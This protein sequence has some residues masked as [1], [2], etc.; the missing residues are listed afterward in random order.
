MKNVKWK[1]MEGAK[2]IARGVMEA[3]SDREAIGR[4][5][6]GSGDFVPVPDKN[7]TI[8]AGELVTSSY[9]DE[10]ERTARA[11]G[12]TDDE[13]PTN[14]DGYQYASPD[15]AKDGFGQSGKLKDSF[16]N[17]YEMDSDGN[18][19]RSVNASQVDSM[20]AQEA[21]DLVLEETGKSTGWSG[22]PT[23]KEVAHCI[24]QL[25]CPATV[26]GHHRWQR[27]IG[28]IEPRHPLG[29][30]TCIQC[31][32]QRSKKN[33]PAHKGGG[34]T[35][36]KITKHLEIVGHDKYAIDTIDTVGRDFVRHIYTIRYT[37]R[38]RD[39]SS[40]KVTGESLAQL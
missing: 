16:G 18:I 22:I 10:F 32:K 34:G 26:K 21:H 11:V 19:S 24:G 17:D 1:L 9:G 23:P 33:Y 39:G 7:Y 20:T 8:H 38:W 14:T 27:Q 37:I 25:L 3:E 35:Y 28:T 13:P 31:G 2:V 15:P 4:V 5:L 6:T 40:H 36:A 29:L 30:E 12:W